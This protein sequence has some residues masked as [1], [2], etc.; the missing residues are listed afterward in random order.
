MSREL[1]AALV[2]YQAIVAKVKA[3]MAKS[4]IDI[5]GVVLVNAYVG[6]YNK[7]AKE[8]GESDTD[9]FIMDKYEQD[10]KSGKVKDVLAKLEKEI[11]ERKTAKKAAKKAEK[12]M[13][14]SS[15]N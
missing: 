10:K 6:K 5:K 2:K 12:A 1:P 7:E 14:D 11:A 3:D 9:K 13:T 8:K 15:S 4:G